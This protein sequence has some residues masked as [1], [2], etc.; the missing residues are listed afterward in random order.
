MIEA[1][2]K[3][4]GRANASYLYVI[5][6]ESHLYIGETGELPP[7]RWGQHLSSGGTLRG[8]TVNAGLSLPGTT[9]IL[10]IGVRCTAIDSVDILKR[11]LAR[12]AIEEE[13]HRQFSLDSWLL[14]KE[15]NILSQAPSPPVRFAWAFDLSDVAMQI[16]THVIKEFQLWSAGADTGDKS[17]PPS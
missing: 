5:V 12:R 2:G 16:R 15:Y 9:D 11:R 8:K 14:G 6:Y 1:A 17:P 3:V 7:K 4:W 13:L 10:F